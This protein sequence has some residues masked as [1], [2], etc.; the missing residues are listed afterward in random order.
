MLSGREPFRSRPRPIRGGSEAPAPASR[1]SHPAERSSGA[2]QSRRLFIADLGPHPVEG[3]GRDD[4]VKGGLRDVTVLEGGFHNGDV[5]VGRHL[6]PEHRG[7]PPPGLNGRRRSHAAQTAMWLYSAGTDFEDA[8][9]R[10]NPAALEKMVDGGVGVRTVAWPR[11]APLAGRGAG[12]V[13]SSPAMSPIFQTPL[14]RRQDFAEVPK[15]RP[16]PAVSHLQDE[17]AVR[18]AVAHPR[19]RVH[20]QLAHERCVD[21]SEPHPK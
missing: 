6:V 1:V 2:Q 18:R 12:G 10:T 8:A 14:T 3:L 9:P 20:Q 5:W 21:F 4:D 16:P 13:S 7:H 19:P 11:N 15:G 17:S